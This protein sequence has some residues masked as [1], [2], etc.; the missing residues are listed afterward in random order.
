M[1]RRFTV[2]Q[3]GLTVT[4]IRLPAP[5]RPHPALTLAW[6]RD[7]QAGTGT[8]APLD[9]AEAIDRA[10]RSRLAA[11]GRP[12]RSVGAVAA[13]ARAVDRPRRTR[14]IPADMFLGVRPEG[15]APPAVS[16]PVFD[17]RAPVIAAPSEPVRVGMAGRLSARSGALRLALLRRVD[18]IAVGLL[19]LGAGPVAW[20]RARG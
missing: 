20:R 14:A 16:V 12:V 18:A 9:A 17:D 3:G 5:D 7:V 11:L 15:W 2:I 4:A 13:P 6:S 10:I 1:A 19:N 8:A